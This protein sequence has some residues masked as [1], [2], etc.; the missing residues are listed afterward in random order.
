MSGDITVSDENGARPATGFS[1]K[2]KRCSVA[3]LAKVLH[4][5]LFVLVTR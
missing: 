5:F 1:K 4:D 3:V 2:R